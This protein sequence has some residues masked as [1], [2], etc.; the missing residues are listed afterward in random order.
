MGGVSRQRQRNNRRKTNTNPLLNAR[1]VRVARSA[2]EELGEGEVGEHI[3]VSL[4]GQ[5]VATHR[6]S[7]EVPGYRG[8]EWNAVLACAE[9][10]SHVTVNEVALMPAQEALQAPAWVPYEDRVRPGDLGP[11]DVMPPRPEDERLESDGH[12]HHLSRRGLQDALQRW[13]TGDYGPT[14]EFAEKA[15]L[16]CRTC[17]FYLPAAEPIGENFGVCANEYSADGHLV[18]ATYGCG[19]HSETPGG[20]VD[21]HPRQDAFDDEAPLEF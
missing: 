13:R 15:Q 4:T 12:R 5:N 20:T 8:W 11:G 7:A 17:A 19:A 21:P 6:F 9:G 10:S 3:G 1:A 18:H 14:S 2:L 16:K